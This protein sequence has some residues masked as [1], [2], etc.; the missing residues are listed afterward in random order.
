[1]RRHWSS[2]GLLASLPTAAAAAAAA[3]ARANIHLYTVSMVTTTR[4]K[5]VERGREEQRAS[6][7]ESERGYTERRRK[8]SYCH[9]TGMS[10]VMN[11]ELPPRQRRAERC[12]N[13][14]VSATSQLY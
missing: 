10:A 13:P 2:S 7:G 1:M 5:G 12:F 4:E 3:V 6:K 8:W 11:W 9:R 14:S